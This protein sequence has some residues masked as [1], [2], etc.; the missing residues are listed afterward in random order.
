MPAAPEQEKDADE[1]KRRL[2][3]TK[4]PRAPVDTNTFALH[5]APVCVWV[6]CRCC[7]CAPHLNPQDCAQKESLGSR[8]QALLS[9]ER[10]EDVVRRRVV[11]VM[12]VS[13]NRRSP[14]SCTDALML[15]TIGYI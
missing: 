12:L 7:S 9:S 1:D 15:H 2:S 8:A 6:A 14:S 3:L 13:H 10:R 5:V 4:Q 11:S